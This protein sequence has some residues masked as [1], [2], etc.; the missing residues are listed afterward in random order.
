EGRTGSWKQVARRGVTLWLPESD[1]PLLALDFEGQVRLFHRRNVDGAV[2]RNRAGVDDQVFLL[3]EISLR[4]NEIDVEDAEVL[5]QEDVLLAVLG[6]R[7]AEPPR[8]RPRI[9]EIDG[10]ARVL[11][12]SAR[13][14]RAGLVNWLGRE[15]QPKDVPVFSG[16]RNVLRPCDVDEIS[17]HASLP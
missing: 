2:A 13:R 9:G 5:H 15:V 8:C 3:E 12:S 1:E 10:K 7:S 6:S 11:L 14:S 16:R 17:P 4:E